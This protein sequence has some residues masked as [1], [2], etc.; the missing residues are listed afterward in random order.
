MWNPAAAGAPPPINNPPLQGA[1]ATQQFWPQWQAAVQYYQAASATTADTATANET[2]AA[3]G[4]GN[5]LIMSN[6]Q[7]IRVL[8]IGHWLRHICKQI[9]SINRNIL[10]NSC[11]NNISMR[12]HRIVKK[13]VYTS[14]I[15]RHL[16][17]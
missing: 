5:I 9:K 7:I 8:T 15:L 11:C 14:R 16:R 10:Q 13:V 3:G 4:G 1:P 17:R 2:A 12:Y 6:I